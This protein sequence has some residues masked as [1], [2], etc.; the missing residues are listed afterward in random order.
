MAEVTCPRCGYAWYLEDK[1]QGARLRRLL[2]KE[3]AKFLASRAK[4][5]KET[6]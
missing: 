6:R 2:K 3:A 5:G 4:Q 1:T